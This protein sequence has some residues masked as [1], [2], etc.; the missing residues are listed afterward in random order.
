MPHLFAILREYDRIVANYFSRE[1]PVVDKE[2]LQGKYGIGKSIATLMQIQMVLVGLALILT[3]YGV[4][5]SYHALPRMIVYILQAIACIAILV[6]GFFHFHKKDNRY[7]KAV[8]YSYAFL[9]AIRCAL[10]GTDGVSRWAAIMARLL[11]V[12]LACLLV[13]LGEHLGEKKSNYIAFMIMFM[14]AAL[15]LVFALG[16]VTERIIFKILPL[17]GILIAAS[18]CLFNTAKIK[19]REYF[20]GLQEEEG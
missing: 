6:F 18:I 15:Y 3:A 16:F 13:L 4:T 7:F 12:G 2:K 8:L 17:V 20:E 10:I 14:E 11:M 1:V 9:E 19:Q 5:T